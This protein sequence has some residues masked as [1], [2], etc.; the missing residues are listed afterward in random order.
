SPFHF[1]AD[2][3][4]ELA[5][6]VARGR[7][8]F[9]AQFPSLALPETQSALP[10]PSDRQ[11]FTACRLDFTERERHSD[12]YNLHRDLLKLRRDD[13]VFCPQLPRLLDGAVLG[14]QTF[15]LR[16][17]AEEGNDR[18]LI[19]NLGPDLHLDPAPEPLLAPPESQAWQVCWSSEDQRY[20]GM[21]T[22]PLEGEDN[23]RIPGEA[24][25]V[26]VPR[27]SDDPISAGA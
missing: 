6:K 5:D 15:V 18:L 27:R 22:P 3:S 23:W 8:E 25:V 20:G 24:A 17:F 1:F 9:L 12:I 16:Y 19:V 7:A 14:P 4:T 2:H 10:D 26:L 21:G 11:T 13:P